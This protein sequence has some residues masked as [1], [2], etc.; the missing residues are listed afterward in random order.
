[1]SEQATAFYN[2]AQG[3][4]LQLHSSINLQII[5]QEALE[6]SRRANEET[7]ALFDGVPDAYAEGLDRVR[8]K[9]RANENGLAT[10]ELLI[11]VAAGAILQI[12][13]Q[14]LSMR[15]RDR[16][17]GPEGRELSGTCIRDLIWHGR[18]QAMHYEETRL[19]PELNERGK[20]IRGR[21]RSTW[22][23]TFQTLNQQNPERFVMKEP[24]QSLAKDVLDLLEWTH[25]YSKLDS[26]MKDILNL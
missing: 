17:N 4:L 5:A 20:V 25:H 19:E 10:G 23:E 24:H 18:N 12:A 7:L 2:R 1:M 15:Y 21:D 8:M 22:V 14:A 9:L 13:K 6:V 11:G 16:T 3:M 26:D